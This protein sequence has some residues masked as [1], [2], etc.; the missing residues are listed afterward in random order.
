MVGREG[1]EP[2]KSSDDRFTVC[3]HWPLGHLPNPLPGGALYPPSQVCRR[4]TWRPERRRPAAAPISIFPMA[5]RLRRGEVP[6]ERYC[7]LGGA[8]G[9]SVN[10]N[11]FGGMKPPVSYTNAFGTAVFGMLNVKTKSAT[12]PGKMSEVAGISL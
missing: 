2:S 5:P 3:S 10:L 8:G 9:G 7:P 11:I 4:H 6:V 1:F 12:A